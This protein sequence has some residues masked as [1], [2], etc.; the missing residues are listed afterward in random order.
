[1]HINR[2]Y[3]EDLGKKIVRRD[4][5]TDH[6]IHEIMDKELKNENKKIDEEI[7]QD[8]RDA[9]KKIFQS[10]ENYFTTVWNISSNQEKE[11]REFFYSLHDGDV[12]TIVTTYKE[13]KKD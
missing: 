5:A 3:L 11:A 4:K 10:T 12:K 2:A 7:L 9:I 1:M 6:N 13:T 8:Y